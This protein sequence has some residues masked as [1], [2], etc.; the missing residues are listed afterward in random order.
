MDPNE[1]LRIMLE[2]AASILKAIDTL[3]MPADD[4][5]LADDAS[6]LSEAVQN[7]NEWLAKGGFLPSKWAR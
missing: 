2:K 6:E 4:V 7:L 1:T 3:N 5:Y